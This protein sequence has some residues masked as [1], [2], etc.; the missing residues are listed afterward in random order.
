MTSP[1]PTF[2]PMEKYAITLNVCNRQQGFNAESR[3]YTAISHYKKL[4]EK[5]FL[6][7]THFKLWIEISKRGRIHLHGTIMFLSTECIYLYLLKCAHHL[8]MDKIV[9]IDIR[10]IK[11]KDGWLKYCN[12]DESIIKPQMDA[13]KIPYPITEDNLID[14]TIDV[15]LA[16]RWPSDI[17][18]MDESDDS[19]SDEH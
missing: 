9:N 15:K 7:F 2:L 1:T 12:K 19:S 11:D 3:M 14:Y 16:E 4:L 18:V 8:H 17:F 10:P 5:Y 6:Q 13:L